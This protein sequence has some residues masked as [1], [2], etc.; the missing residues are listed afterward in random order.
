MELYVNGI[1][2]HLE[3]AITVAGSLGKQALL[4]AFYHRSESAVRGFAANV[5]KTTILLYSDD[6]EVLAT[7][8]PCDVDSY[9]TKLCNGREYVHHGVSISQEIGNRFIITDVEGQINDM[10]QYLMNHFT[11]PLLPEWIPFILDNN[12]GKIKRCLVDCYGENGESK[13]QDR[14]VYECLLTDEDLAGIVS[15]GLKN[16]K[17]RISEQEQSDL[18]F[19]N[20]DDYFQNY[21]HTLVEN[22][23]NKLNPLVPLKER[24]DD[25]AFLHK[26][27]FPQQAAIANGLIENMN[28]R[29]Y[30]IENL[31]MGTG[32]TVISLAVIEGFFNRRYLK[33]YPEKTLKDLYLDRDAIKFRNIIMCPSH[34][35][36]K[37]ASSI[38][39]DIPYAKTVIVR[40]LKEL[41]ALKKRGRERTCKEFYI[42]SKDLGKLS[43]MY[44][45]IPSQ[46]KY[47]EVK[48]Y[49]CEECGEPRP[50]DLRKRCS[51]GSDKWEL[52]S[53]DYYAEGL[54]CPECG[55]LLFP[56]D[57]IR[58]RL[59]P[60]KED[61]HKPL[62]PMDFATQTA[63]NRTCRHCGSALWQPSCTPLDQTFFAPRNK[64]KRKKWIRLSHFANKTRKG[65]KTAWVYQRE[66]DEYILVN[67]IEE[68]DIEY[69]NV[70]GP[71]K[72]APARYI[73]KQ[74]KG[75]FD[76]AIID[77]AHECESSKL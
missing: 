37:W 46:V 77:E 60:E 56:A 32:K 73:K 67:N 65:R 14:V 39:E 19:E 63:A 52:I 47:K 16:K 34:L 71:R 59:N 76:V 62:L 38:E 55:E 21:G 29:S 22:L 72:Y 23:E 3:Y 8:D 66:I 27:L 7:F 42:M 26:R 12:Q 4:Y 18:K 64:K 74:L 15:N 49:V 6:K 10:Y 1:S 75:F 68:E 57:V 45:P 24:L 31:D 44:A 58:L 40:G 11:L 70:Y 51:C 48:Q 53:Q 13:G 36:E 33:S 41:V 35:V 9:F 69:P 28:H 50:K 5:G 20:M 54:I 25:V 2:A 30:G 43:Y 17:I 61:R